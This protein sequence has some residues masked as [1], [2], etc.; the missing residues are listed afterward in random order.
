[1]R[2]FFPLFWGGET[3]CDAEAVNDVNVF[4]CVCVC[5]CACVR[6]CACVHSFLFFSSFFLSTK[7]GHQTLSDAKGSQR[8]LTVRGSAGEHLPALLACPDTQGNCCIA[9]E[10]S[11]AVEQSTAVE[12]STA[13]L[14]LSVLWLYCC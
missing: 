14:L 4:V 11:T 3:R 8:E 13:I 12:H 2:A 5:V 6:V 1:M 9:V 7:Y 10:H